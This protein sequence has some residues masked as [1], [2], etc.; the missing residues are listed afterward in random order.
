LNEPLPPPAKSKA[1]DNVEVTPMPPYQSLAYIKARYLAGIADQQ[2]IVGDKDEAP[3]VLGMALSEGAKVGEPISAPLVPTTAQPPALTQPAP[4]APVG[5]LPNAVAVAAEDSET[6]R[7]S[8]VT[9]SAN[10]PLYFY[11]EI[12]DD[13]YYGAGYQPNQTVEEQLYQAAAKEIDPPA[14]RAEVL[15]ASAGRLFK[16]N[17][18]ASGKAWSEALRAASQIA[19][20]ARSQDLPNPFGASP[21][22][23]NVQNV[24]VQ[25]MEKALAYETDLDVRSYVFGGVA[26]MLFQRGEIADG[27]A[28]TRTMTKAASPLTILTK[29]ASELSDSKNPAGAKQL[30]PDIYKYTNEISDDSTRLNQFMDLALFEPRLGLY[31]ESRL[32]CPA[33]VFSELQCYAEILMHYEIHQNPKLFQ[34]LY[35]TSDERYRID[36]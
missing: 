12:A 3:K 2:Y 34:D 32:A 15:A 36:W 23:A 21:A 30:L 16:V 18:A 6:V 1:G 5:P 24:A 33:F 7:R 20:Y 11:N 29:M 31:R 13:L 35:V 17:A 9:L 22:P 26:E 4:P 25:Q 28:V 19:D 14:V 10:S 27:L 8:Q